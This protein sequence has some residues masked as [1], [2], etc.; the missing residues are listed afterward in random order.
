MKTLREIA[1]YL[2][3]AAKRLTDATQEM[4][5]PDF[6][7]TDIMAA[8]KRL[9]GLLGNDR[10]FTISPPC[11]NFYASG[12]KLD[13]WTV[14]L[15]PGTPG[16]DNVNGKNFDGSTLADAVNAVIAACRESATTVQDVVESM[17]PTSF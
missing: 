16:P 1:D 5:R 4:T 15:S 10:Y 13:C 6:G 9:R 17:S 2:T 3:E 12:I 7:D 14:Y 8:A 11:V